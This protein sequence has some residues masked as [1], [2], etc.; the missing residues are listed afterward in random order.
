M[1]VVIMMVMVVI[2]MVMVGLVGWCWF[3]DNDDNIMV[4]VGKRWVQ[5]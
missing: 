5:Q 4:T 1:T 2:K 3:G